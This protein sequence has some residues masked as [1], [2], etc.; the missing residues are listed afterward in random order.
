MGRHV[1]L[2]EAEMRRPMTGVAGPHQ[3]IEL[4]VEFLD[5]LSRRLP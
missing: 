1:Q 4:G 5:V 3:F 2:Y